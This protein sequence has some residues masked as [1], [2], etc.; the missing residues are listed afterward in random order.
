MKDYPQTVEDWCNEAYQAMKESWDEITRFNPQP[1]ESQKQGLITMATT[2]ACINRDI[3]DPVFVKHAQEYAQEAF[4]I[5]YASRD[6]TASIDFS[7]C[8]LLAYFDSHLALN[9][10][11]QDIVDDSIAH[12]RTQYD[13]SYNGKTQNNVLSINFSQ[14]N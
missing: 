2:S 6:L 11:T 8:Y 12:L 7:L 9:L 1:S 14:K 4:D 3:S 5:D 10:V 13:L